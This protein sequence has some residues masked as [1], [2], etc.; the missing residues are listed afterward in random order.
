VATI[1]DFQQML[2]GVALRVTHPR[3]AVLGAVQAR[4]RRPPTGGA[5]SAERF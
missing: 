1:I 4:D 3:I 5:H 2:R